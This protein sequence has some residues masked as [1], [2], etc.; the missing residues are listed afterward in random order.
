MKLNGSK[1]GGKHLNTKPSNKYTA[2]K[3][4][5]SLADDET[6]FESVFRSGRDTRPAEPFMEV[7]ASEPKPSPKPQPAPPKPRREEPRPAPKKEEPKPKAEKSKAEPKREEKKQQKKETKRQKAGEA[8]AAKPVEPYDEEKTL[9]AIKKERKKKKRRK[10][11]IRLLITL[12]VLAGLYVFGIYT[13]FGPI[14]ALRDAYI[15]TAMSTMSHQWLAEWFIPHSV[16]DEVMDKVADTQEAQHGIKSLWN[17]KYRK[18]PAEQS[19]ES[20]EEKFYE[21]FREIDKTSFKYYVERHPEVIA[22]GWDKIYIN[23]AGIDDKGTDIS[24]IY[25]DRILAVDAVNQILLIR[26]EGSGYQGVLALAKDSSRLSCCEADVRYGYG[27]YLADIVEKNNGILGMNASGFI[28]KDGVG[29]GADLCG[30]AMTNGTEKGEHADYSYK[31]IELHSDNLMYIT[32]AQS[33]VSPDTTDAVEFTPAII[34]DG[35]V[36][37]DEYSGYSSINPRACIGQNKYG[38]VMMLVIE[39]RLVGRSLGTTLPECAKILE[40]YDAAQIINLDGGTSAIMWYRGE[41]VIK[42]SNPQIQCR[43]LPNAWIYK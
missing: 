10:R 14:K 22:D 33:G 26:V 16:I 2:P 24:T 32:D 20:E 36:L 29:S 15:E 3:P 21:L 42:C 40:R 35:K 41:Y 31:R 28:D 11:R 5:P 17:E 6:P 12:A 4:K 23:E 43:F 9:A 8:A 39:G 30:Y 34:V 37:I 18:E 7:P 38:E 25:G 27:Q 13:Q 19:K 1:S